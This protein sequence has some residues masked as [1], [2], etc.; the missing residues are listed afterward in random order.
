MPSTHE[1]KSW[2]FYMGARHV[3]MVLLRHLFIR[4]AD[5]IF[6]PLYASPT[7]GVLRP[8]YTAQLHAG[9]HKDARNGIVISV[10]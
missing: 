2:W 3:P 10:S 4:N 9:T 7:L 1:V 5:S 6:P 8:K